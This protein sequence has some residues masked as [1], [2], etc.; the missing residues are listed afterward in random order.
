VRSG[1]FF[2]AAALRETRVAG[3]SFV[4]PRLEKRRGV[5][6]ARASRRYERQEAI[7]SMHMMVRRPMQFNARGPRLSSGR[8]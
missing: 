2:G 7:N 5:P 1:A 3:R 6:V 4:S 8:A